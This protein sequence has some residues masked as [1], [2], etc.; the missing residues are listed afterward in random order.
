MTTQQELL[1]CSAPEDRERQAV[2]PTEIGP[3]RLLPMRAGLPFSELD[4]DDARPKP[5]AE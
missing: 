5:T 1:R 4:D 3:N 2:R